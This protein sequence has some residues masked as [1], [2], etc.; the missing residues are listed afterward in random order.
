MSC[1]SRVP[2]AQQASG[3]VCFKRGL[4]VGYKVASINAQKKTDKAILEARR[5]SSQR[6]RVLQNIRLPLL[7]MDMSKD[8]LREF[9]RLYKIPNYGRISKLQLFNAVRNKILA[10]GREQYAR[11]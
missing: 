5:I 4:R 2:V 8:T 6:A 3:P 10:G 1:S 11:L 9:A 7:S